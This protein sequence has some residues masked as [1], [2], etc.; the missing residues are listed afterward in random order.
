SDFT[1]DNVEVFD[2]TNESGV[3]RITNL[4]SE[5]VGSTYT[6]SFENSLSQNREYLA[7]TTNQT[8]QPTDIQVYTDSGIYSATNGADYI[9]ITHE[10][11]CDSIQPLADY[12]EEQGLRV[13]IVKIEDIYDEF[14]HGI[15]SPQAIKDFLTYTYNSWAKPAPTYVL[16]VGDTTYDY[17]DNKGT[18]SVNYVPT[19][20]LDT[21]YM[22]ETASDNWF[23]CV[24]GDDI[25]PDMYIGRLEWTGRRTIYQHLQRP[26]PHIDTIGRVR[27]AW[28]IGKRP[29]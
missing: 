7:L 4:Q 29:G 25:I 17:K 12:R 18:G 5:L 6:V 10:D 27:S 9:V 14:N 1:T 2:I 26:R 20:L 24:S 19:Y 13:K 8:K 21:D 28:L 16:L 23:V 11:F 3:K 22:G 15:F